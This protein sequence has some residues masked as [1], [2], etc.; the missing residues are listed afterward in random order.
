MTRSVRSTWKQQ[1]VVHG[2]AVGVLVTN[3]ACASHIDSH[4]SDGGSLTSMDAHGL[5]ERDGGPGCS[6]CGPPQEAG[7]GPQEAGAPRQDAG[8]LPPAGDAGC[9]VGSYV[10]PTGPTYSTQGGSETLSRIT[11]WSPG[12]PGGVPNVTTVY[13]TL[14]ATGNADDGPINNALA[15]CPA[16]QVVMLNPGT[17]QIT[18]PILINKSSVV[19]RGTGGPGAGMSAQTRLI[20]TASLVGPIVNIGPDLFPG[21]AA[22][23]ADCTAD[24][25]QGATSVAVSSAS[26]FHVGD[27][28]LVDVTVDPADDTGAW[29]LSAPTGQTGLAYPYG[30]YNPM[31]S[32]KGDPSRGWFS[33]TNRPVSQ[34]MEIQ[35]ISGTTLTFSTP[36]H[37]TYDVAHAAQVTA[38][39]YNGSSTTPTT[40]SGLEDLYVAGPPGAGGNNQDNNVVLTLAKY[41]WVK[42]VESDQ[43]NGDSIGLDSAF[44]C[45]VRDSYMHSTINPSPGGA[46]YGLEFSFGSADNLAENNISWNFNKIMVM[47]ASGGGNVIAYN[48]MDDGWINYNPTWME[49]GLNAAH[50]TTPH[51]ELFE[52]NLSFAIETDDTWGGAVAQTWLRNVATGHRSAWPPLNTYTYNQN[53]SATGCASSGPN[54]Q[55]CLAY[56]DEQNRHP[57]GA[58]YGH[59]FYNYVGN[60]AGSIGM[61]VA[62][63]VNGF[64][65]QCTG[66]DWNQ[67][68]TPMWILGY[69]DNDNDTDQG[70]VNTTFRDGNFDYSTN[71]VKWSGS[72][73]IVPSSLYLCGKPAFFGSM[74]WPW[75]DGSDA[76]HPYSTHS[77]Q[78]YPLS[79][80]L[81]T[82]GTSGALVTYAG[83]QLPA[84]VRYLQII[85]VE[86]PPATCA[87]STVANAPA[88][89]TLLLTGV[90]P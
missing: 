2:L 27:L 28:V 3:S 19:L 25:M 40:H 20:G 75:S 7:A 70:V 67:D 16:D 90:S 44:R 21:P 11:T 32:P 37:M 24:A 18:N 23:S 68:P 30:E 29:I 51:F 87:S 33:R 52:G 15:A 31:N 72:T 4:S 62:P 78:Y 22:S 81:G 42:N 76:S 49:A 65:Y 47:R 39:T 86:K 57:A 35:S 53:T 43:S 89:C 77:F 71:T 66:P 1:A 34:L 14:S 8:N 69:D 36:F 54:D 50:M 73:Q 64:Q 6:P 74:S 63:E 13:K 61:P 5:M 9:G 48:Y 79:P 45:V 82:F 59:V 41:S 84:F 60:V 38:M 46:G 58:Q 17:Y 56:T 88:G 12:I 26:A 85:S 83:Y 80:S 55:V 10:F